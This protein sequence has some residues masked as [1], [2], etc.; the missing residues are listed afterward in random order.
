MMKPKN[1]VVNDFDSSA[2]NDALKLFDSLEPVDIDFMMGKWKGSGY[3]TGH[4]L[5]GLLER[6]HW[7]GKY[8]LSSEDVHPLVYRTLGGKLANIE[9]RLIT[10]AC[11]KLV[12]ISPS[13]VRS[14]T[15]VTMFR[16]FLPLLKTPKSRARLRMM[17]Y[18]GKVSAT[19][20]YDDL[21]INDAFRKLDEHTVLGVMDGKDIDGPFFFKLTREEK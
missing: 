11:V 18:R 6:Y 12:K 5:D 21:P 9:P 17:E 20:V 19:M 2:T 10:R 14:K 13:I 15:A 3:E 7:H 1:F 4:A 8:F 16:C